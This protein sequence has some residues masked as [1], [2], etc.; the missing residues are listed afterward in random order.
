[1]R[2]ESTKLGEL[3]IRCFLP[4]VAFRLGACRRVAASGGSTTLPFLGV[5]LHVDHDERDATRYGP[6]THNQARQGPRRLGPSLGGE[7]RRG[8]A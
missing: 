5:E 4:G 8:E 6:L 3:G 1:M 7:G 2:W